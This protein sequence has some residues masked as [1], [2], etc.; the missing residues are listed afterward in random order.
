MATLSRGSDYDLM[1]LFALHRLVRSQDDGLC[2]LVQEGVVSTRFEAG[3]YH[4]HY[5]AMNKAFVR[6]YLEAVGEQRPAP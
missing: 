5:E 4:A 1:E 2:E 6:L 3:P